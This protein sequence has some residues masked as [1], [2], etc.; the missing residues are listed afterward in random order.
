MINKSRSSSKSSSRSSSSSRSRSN[1]R[2]MRVGMLIEIY[3]I[4]F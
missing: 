1:N 4:Y 2:I 3:N